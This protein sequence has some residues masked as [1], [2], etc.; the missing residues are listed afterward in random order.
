METLTVELGERSYPIKIGR[1][2]F[3]SMI[4]AARIPQQIRGGRRCAVAV[5]AQVQ[6]IHGEA[7]EAAFPDA[8]KWIMPSG[9]T[10]KSMS[11]AEEFLQFL[12]DNQLNRQSFLVA[13]G[14]GV[15]GDLCGFCAAIY[16]RGI[17]YYQ[18]PT[19]LLSM[20][21][22]S[23]GGKTGVNLKAGKNLVGAFLQPEA[24]SVWLPFL[25]TLPEREFSAGMAEV[26]KYGLLADDGLFHLLEK[27][28]SIDASSPVLES[29]IVRCCG[30]KAAI[31]ANDETEQA[32]EGGRALLNLGH[33][34]GHAIEA[35][36]GYGEYLHG[37]AVAIGTL[38]AARFSALNGF[39]EED[40]VSR[41]QHLIAVNGLP[42]R[43]RQ[44]IAASQLLAA[45]K[46]DKKVRSGHLR[47]V[48]LDAIGSARTHEVADSYQL[49]E[50]WKEFGA[51]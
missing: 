36:A 45:M 1:E 13:I 22:S 15:L 2:Q 11:L 18:I 3:E 24:V 7:I 25:K 10:S 5:D 31:V 20:V 42:D 47:L 33:T 6:K 43:L 12:A 32:K 14:G 9:E 41:I 17:A 38:M 51:E 26:I 27:S 35:V 30:I 37:E 19:T 39:I 4:T 50:L 8:P 23:V 29:I 48:V 40:S 44:P 49:E 21:D 16:L 34:F 28:G 46:R